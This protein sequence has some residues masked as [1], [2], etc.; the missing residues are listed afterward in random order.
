[1]TEKTYILAC[2]TEWGLTAF[3]KRRPKLP[4]QWIC[5]TTDKDLTAILSC[6]Y[7]R[8]VFFPHWSSKVPGGL[9]G[10][11][12]C[13]AFHMTDLPFGRG[14]TPLQ[15]L[16]ASGAKETQVTAFRMTN[17]LDAGPVYVKKRMSLEGSADEIYARAANIS[18]ELM[19]WIVEREPEPVPQLGESTS[20]R[21]RQPRES[22]IS[23]QCNTPEKLYDHIR[24][25][26]ANGYPRAFLDYGGWHF[27]FRDA[28]TDGESI[29][30]TVSITRV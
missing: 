13:V 10:S 14:G 7:P 22:V 27:E 23:N 3:L 26:D 4:G 20:F 24:M 30:A 5:V 15:N 19:E 25:L 16:I 21:R 8:Y 28:E 12:E 29:H 1:M 17:E 11:T 9:I 2:S 18:F 6:D